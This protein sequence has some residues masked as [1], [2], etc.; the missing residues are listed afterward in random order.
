M[1]MYIIFKMTQT[2]LSSYLKYLATTL[3]A[4]FGCLYFTGIAAAE[5]TLY[6]PPNWLKTLPTPF[7][8]STNGSEGSNQTNAFA[9][10][11]FSS[12]VTRQ[13]LLS[14]RFHGP[15]LFLPPRLVLGECAEFIVQG[16][17]GSFVALAMADKNS[18]AK[19]ICGHDLKLGADRKLVGVSKIPDTGIASI[20]I[21]API[22]GDLVGSS[23]YFEA[24]VW[25][26]P[27]FSD[28]QLASAVSPQKET[29][30]ENG[31]IVCEQPTEKKAHML[32][33][34]TGQPMSSK[35]VGALSSG[36]P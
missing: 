27:D 36:R 18:G 34:N 30:G 19:P 4:V 15:K 33:I 35:T 32:N 6:G 2:Q 21:E 8:T 9:P 16:P 24:T 5:D 13:S 28:M 25:S 17:P 10:I 26:K 11:G 31:V 7:T 14:E 23:L 22:Q 3:A 29:C 12:Q 1:H 20:T